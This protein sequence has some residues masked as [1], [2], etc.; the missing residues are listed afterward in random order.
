MKIG[1]ITPMAEEKIALIAALEN[2]ATKRHG[3]TEI[4]TGQYHGHEIVLT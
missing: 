4:T 3:G 2:T 1:I